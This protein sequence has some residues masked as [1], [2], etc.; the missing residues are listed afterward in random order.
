M[1]QQEA[2]QFLADIASASGSV[3]EDRYFSIL[4]DHFSGVIK[5]ISKENIEYEDLGGNTICISNNFFEEHK[6]KVYSSTG[7]FYRNYE[8][9]DWT[10]VILGDKDNDSLVSRVDDGYIN[11]QQYSK[12]TADRVVTNFFYLKRIIGLL[13]QPKITDYKDTAHERYFFLSP[14]CGK[15]EINEGGLDNLIAIAEGSGDLCETYKKFVEINGCQHG[16]EFILK[17]KIIKGLEGVDVE[18]DGFKELIIN[19]ALFIGATERDYELF[20]NSRKY[21]AVIQQFEN[22]K[23]ILA[24]KIRSILQRMS[25]SIISIPVTFIGAIIA[26]NNIKDLWFI[27]TIVFTMVIF[28]VLSSI[29]NFLFWGDLDILKDEIN[30]RINIISMGLPRLHKDLEKII[31]PFLKRIK[32]MRR[33]II[34]IILLFAFLFLFFVCQYT[35]TAK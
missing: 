11:F 18:K 23:Y 3:S 9:T 6:I 24:D 26:I 12:K 19:L 17:N 14:E 10:A 34:A 21:E 28:I 30:M 22:E 16:W 27:N 15:L 1:N 8:E 20:L 29:I 5:I 35:S 33:L 13:S 7:N 25:G 4:P 32:F 31:M 2:I